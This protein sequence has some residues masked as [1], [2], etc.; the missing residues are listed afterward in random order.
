[1][2]GTRSAPIMPRDVSLSDSNC[3]ENATVGKNGLKEVNVEEVPPMIRISHVRAFCNHAEISFFHK[4]CCFQLHTMCKKMKMSH[5]L[6]L[7]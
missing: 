6:D 2:G 7:E 4:R 5:H 1:M 3:C